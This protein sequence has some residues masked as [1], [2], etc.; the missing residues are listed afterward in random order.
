M[1]GEDDVLTPMRFANEMSQRIE[2][3]RVVTLEGTGHGFIT[4]RG[5][6]IADA[7]YGFLREGA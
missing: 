2:G 3:S 1:F 6:E 5:K 7:V 4:T